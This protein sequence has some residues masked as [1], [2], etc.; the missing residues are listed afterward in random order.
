[1]HLQVGFTV[2]LCVEHS[3]DLVIRR[4]PDRDLRLEGAIAPALD[5]GPSPVVP[6]GDLPG[7]LAPIIAQEYLAQK[8]AYPPGVLIGFDTS[9]SLASY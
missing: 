5:A 2:S 1:M 6:A 4:L 9:A 7:D 3:S 8:G